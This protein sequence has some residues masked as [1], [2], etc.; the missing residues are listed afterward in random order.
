MF[1]P[2]HGSAPDI[3]GK[4]KANPLA[5]VLTIGMMLTHLGIEGE[6]AKLTQLVKDAVAAG[7]TTRDLGGDKKTSEVGRW[8][9]DRV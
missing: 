9:I 3:A 1:E 6:E 4:D 7:M 8:V 2:V 5:T